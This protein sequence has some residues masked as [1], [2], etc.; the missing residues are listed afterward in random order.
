MPVLIQCTIYIAK[1]VT[2]AEW[3][4][5]INHFESKEIFSLQS[6]DASTFS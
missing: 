5:R 3:K 1:A 2:L 4:K 6:C